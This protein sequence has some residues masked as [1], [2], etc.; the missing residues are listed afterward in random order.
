MCDLGGHASSG[1]F[2]PSFVEGYTHNSPN[3]DPGMKKD[4]TGRVK[5]ASFA[6]N[7]WIVHQFPSCASQ[8]D[9]RVGGADSAEIWEI[10][11]EKTRCVYKSELTLILRTK[12]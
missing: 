7:T 9:R 3:H 10:M 11:A 4:H 8:G 6:L 2:I 1:I 5:D 12:L